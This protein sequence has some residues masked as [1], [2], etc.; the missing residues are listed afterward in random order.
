MVQA[1][2][3]LA[4]LHEEIID[5]VP[6]TQKIKKKIEVNGVWED[7]QFIR[8]PVRGVDRLSRGSSE[9][10][11][12]CQERYGEPKYL[13]PWFKVSGYI[14]LDERTYVWWKLCE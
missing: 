1:K 14:V 2:M 7:R 5:V 6:V 4:P 12:W 3:G 9:L 10:E 13:G 11:K 8:I